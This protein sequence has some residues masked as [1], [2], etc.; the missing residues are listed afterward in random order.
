MENGLAL[1]L[2]LSLVSNALQILTGH[3]DNAEF[4]LAMRPTEP[5]VLS[6]GKDKSVVLWSIQDHISSAA[7]DPK[8]NMNREY[9]KETNRDVVMIAAAKLIANDVVPKEYLASEI[10]SHFECIGQ[11]WL[12][13]LIEY[14]V[15][16]VHKINPEEMM[17]SFTT[18]SGA[19]DVV[20]WKEYLPG[21]TS[22][23]CNRKSE[24]SLAFKSGHE[25]KYLHMF[26]LVIVE[27]KM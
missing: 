13:P 2:A 18:P 19:W 17:C 1:E 16:N 27:S 7:M 26:A 20:R 5:Y 23:E 22:V 15:S 3:Q 25:P 8:S 6:G 14:V 24:A 9:A 10:V 4:A 21:M 11:V 12:I